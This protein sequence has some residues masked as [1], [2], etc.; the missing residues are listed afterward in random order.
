M[1]A[2]RIQV[3]IKW[4]LVRNKAGQEF[5]NKVIFFFEKAGSSVPKLC[6]E[7]HQLQENVYWTRLLS[8]RLG[9]YLKS[10]GWPQSSKRKTENKQDI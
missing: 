9:F 8:F 1:Q 2:R 3:I 4:G 10:M 6:L 7:V 5:S